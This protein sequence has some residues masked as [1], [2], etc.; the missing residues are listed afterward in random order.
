[1]A[2]NGYRHPATRSFIKPHNASSES[3]SGWVQHHP[4]TQCDRLILKQVH[5]GSVLGSVW[6]HRVTC[7]VHREA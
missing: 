2:A 6:F 7:G 4:A 1:M 3:I 5:W